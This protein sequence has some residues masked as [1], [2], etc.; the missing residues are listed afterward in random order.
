MIFFYDALPLCQPLYK[1][2]NP[3]NPPHLFTHASSCMVE[4]L[5]R[6]AAALQLPIYLPAT[7]S[8]LSIPCSTMQVCE[9]S[10][11]KDLLRAATALPGSYTRYEHLGS[12]AAGQFVVAGGGDAAMSRGQRQIM[13][14][15]GELGL[16][17]RW[18]WPLAGGW[19]H[20]A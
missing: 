3:H 6:V 11:V 1:P 16:L 8:P 19:G 7:L 15:L 10:L 14:S 12:M 18:G 17:F 9:A 20:I 13:H 5:L 4:D 2:T